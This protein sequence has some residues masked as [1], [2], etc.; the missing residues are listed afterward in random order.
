MIQNKAHF[1]P[2]F[3]ASIVGHIFNINIFKSSSS[4]ASMRGTSNLSM[5]M[6]LLDWKCWL[7]PLFSIYTLNVYEK[8]EFVQSTIASAKQFWTQSQ[9]KQTNMDCFILLGQLRFT[10]KWLAETKVN[11]HSW[12]PIN[13]Q[14]DLIKLM[15]PFFSN[16][17]FTWL[18]DITLFAVIILF[19]LLLPQWSL[20]P[21]I[22][23]G[24][25]TTSD[26]QLWCQSSDPFLI[27]MSFQGNLGSHGFKFISQPRPLLELQCLPNIPTWIFDRH[28]NL[29]YHK[30]HPWC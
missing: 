16:T 21:G 4:K 9:H 2:W 27:S 7:Y 23:A 20:L 15:S 22:F 19:I 29:T 11:S 3:K 17:L 25:S 18:L 6:F 8:I 30:N 28:A 26:L 1:S 10:P 5:G 12:L 13:Y 24:A 14:Q